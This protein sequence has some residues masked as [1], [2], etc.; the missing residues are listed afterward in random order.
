MFTTKTFFFSL[1]SPSRLCVGVSRVFQ[2][3]IGLRGLAPPQPLLTRRVGSGFW[4]TGETPRDASQLAQSGGGYAFYGACVCHVV[5]LGEFVNVLFCDLAADCYLS[6]IC[7]FSFGALSC[8]A[9]SGDTTEWPISFSIDLRAPCAAL[10]P[11]AA[12]VALWAK[13]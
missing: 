12:M 10:P 2:L 3:Y 1:L 7:F 4:D 8:L 5:R 11:R 9:F 6:L 13:P